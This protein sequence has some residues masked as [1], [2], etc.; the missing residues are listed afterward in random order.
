M[1]RRRAMQLF[2][3]LFSGVLLSACAG[4][5]SAE[6]PSDQPITVPTAAY[7]RAL[8]DG[9]LALDIDTSIVALPEILPVTEA[10]ELIDGIDEGRNLYS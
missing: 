4:S 8:Y 1:N 5:R 2:P 9:Y 10:V 6:T 7:E 3:V